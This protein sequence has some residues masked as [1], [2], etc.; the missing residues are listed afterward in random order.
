MNTRTVLAVG[1]H[2]D[3]IELG[4]GGTIAR[5]TSEGTQV[6]CVYLT[7]GEKSGEPGT[8]E[9]ES[10]QACGLLGV[11]DVRFADFKDTEVP[12]KH[13]GV[14]FLEKFYDKYQPTIVFT[15]SIH[16]MHQDHRNAAYLSLAAFRYVPGI[17]S[18]ETPRVM[19]TFSPNYFIDISHWIDLKRKALE[20]HRSQREKTYMNYRSMVNLASYRGRQ[21]S[22]EAAEAFEVVRYVELQPRDIATANP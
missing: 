5:Y 11:R 21:A 18:Y 12:C 3:D 15:H 16:E 2:P 8:R 1:A 13:D 4:C 22:I 10:I 7:R 14:E 20:M 9:S 6:I 19:G 17:L